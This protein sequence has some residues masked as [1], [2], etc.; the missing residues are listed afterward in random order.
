LEQAVAI[1][2]VETA[3]QD[4]ETQDTPTVART[5]GVAVATAVG[6]VVVGAAVVEAALIPAVLVGAAAALAPKFLPNLG[7]RLKPLATTTVR[8]AVKLGRKARSAVAEAQ[9][10]IGDIS[11]EVHAEEAAAAAG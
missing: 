9:E 5:D 1:D 7:D 8:G 4:T 11:A 2:P 6:V 3:H 10:R